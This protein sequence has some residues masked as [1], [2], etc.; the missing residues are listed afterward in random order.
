MNQSEF[1]KKANKSVKA[2]DVPGWDSQVHIKKMSLGDRLNIMKQ[3]QAED[4]AELSIVMWCSGI[5]DERGNCLFRYPEDRDKLKS[6]D[7]ESMDFILSEIVEW[8]GLSRE[9]VDDA[10]KN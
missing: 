8:N 10:E 2:I 5:C 4:I 3:H 6:M 1:L 7:P 9:A